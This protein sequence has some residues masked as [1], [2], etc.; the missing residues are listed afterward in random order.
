MRTKKALV[1]GLDGATLDLI[2]PW[3]EA[4]Q[5][6]TFARL[7][8]AG[9]WGRLRTVPNT[10]TAPAWSSFATG[11]NPAERGARRRGQTFWER[12][13]EAGYRPIVINV[14]FSY[15]ANPLNGVM[16]SGIDAPDVSRASC[17]RQARRGGSQRPW[18]IATRPATRWPCIRDTP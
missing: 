6:P 12:A 2:E 5:L 4:G 10:D 14:P 3:V 8:Q 17:P 18:P 13:N 15:P 1:V 7:M 11:L 16:V 9:S